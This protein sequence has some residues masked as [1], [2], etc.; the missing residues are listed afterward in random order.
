MKTKLN[1]LMKITVAASLSL[2]LS[3]NC[4]A[5]LSASNCGVGLFDCLHWYVGANIGVSHL[6]DNPN[7]NFRATNSVS[8]NG[9]GWNVNGGALFMHIYDVVMGGELG[10]TQYADSR[11]N[12]TG[13]GAQSATFARTEHFSVYAALTGLY[14]MV[15]NFSLL[16]KLGVAYG[17]ARKTAI[18]FGTTASA[19][20][21]RPYGALGL[22]YNLTPKFT[23]I[24]QAARD[25]GSHA[26]GSADLY[27]IGLSYAIT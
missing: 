23:V 4:F 14:P 8:E 11:E 9:P 15:Y 22:G 10:Y 16:G 19:T 6:H 20:S 17:Y 26:T 12:I 2:A 24:G 5:Y 21:Y 13:T 25:W 1:S 7:P 3:S 18:G 27:S